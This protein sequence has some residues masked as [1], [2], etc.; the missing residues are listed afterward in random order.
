[1][2]T[3]HQLKALQSCEDCPGNKQLDSSGYQGS[4]AGHIYRATYDEAPINEVP[5]NVCVCLS[6]KNGADGQVGSRYKTHVPHRTCRA[7][8]PV[9]AGH[10][11]G[12]LFMLASLRLSRVFLL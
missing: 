9:Q 3:G 5:L 10:M 4:L 2:R 12:S 6:L 8:R 11:A 1:M 7:H